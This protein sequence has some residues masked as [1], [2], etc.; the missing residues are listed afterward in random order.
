MGKGNMGGAAAPGDVTRR[1]VGLRLVP[2]AVLLAAV[3]AAPWAAPFPF[4]PA[5][6][7][8]SG[9]TN[10]HGV[11]AADVNGDGKRDL[12][13]ANAGSS[14]VGVL[15]GNGDGTFGAAAT[16]PTGAAPKAVAVARLDGDLAVDLVT[17]NQDSNTVSVLKGRG[18]GTL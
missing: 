1:P 3:V 4:D 13:V 18:D 7:F 8:P 9:G 17:A 2:F 15:R 12:I 16:Y 6:R 14:S 11:V 10:P 5:T